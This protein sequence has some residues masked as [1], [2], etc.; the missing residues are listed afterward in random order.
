MKTFIFS[1]DVE[2]WRVIVSGVQMPIVAVSNTIIPK[3]EKDWDDQDMSTTRKIIFSDRIILSL[4]SD[5]YSVANILKYFFNLA[6][7]LE[8]KIC[9]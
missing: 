9:H 2:A 7:K 4:I 6:V 1:R 8:M 5:R 3:V